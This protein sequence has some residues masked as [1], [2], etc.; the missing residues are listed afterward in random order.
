MVGLIIFLLI[1]WLVVSV[2]GFTVKGLLWLAFVGL[3]LFV[4]TGIIG[5][6]RRGVSK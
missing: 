1:L 4:V 3:I 2:I 5:W 6:I